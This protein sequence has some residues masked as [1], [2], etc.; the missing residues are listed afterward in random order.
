[1]MVPDLSR[2]TQM[3]QLPH[4]LLSYY[5]YIYSIYY[6][7]IPHTHVSISMCMYIYIYIQIDMCVCVCDMYTLICLHHSTWTSRAWE[8]ISWICTRPTRASTI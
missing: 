5:I 8:L 1:M 4:K 6:I 2:G 7:Y 3:T